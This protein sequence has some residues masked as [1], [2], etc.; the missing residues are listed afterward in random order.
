MVSWGEDYSGTGRHAGGGFTAPPSS[1]ASYPTTP[2]PG[3]AT[4]KDQKLVLDIA[5]NLNRFDVDPYQ[6]GHDLDK[7]PIPVQRYLA[8]ILFHL[9][10]MWS[11]RAGLDPNHPLEMQYQQA[12]AALAG[13]NTIEVEATRLDEIL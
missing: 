1:G 7:L 13:L 12:R 11:N 8:D 3:R 6:I 5:S 9:L 2:G 10:L 4:N